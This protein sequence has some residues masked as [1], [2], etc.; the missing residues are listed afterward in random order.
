MLAQNLQDIIARIEKARIAY[1]RHQIVRIVAVSKTQ[2]ADAIRTLY[3]AGQRAFGENR[4]QD[5]CDKDAALEALPI[6][7]HFIGT[8]QTNKIN[9]LLALRPSLLHSLHSQQLAHALQKRLEKQGQN[10][11]AL[12]QINAAREDSKHGVAPESASETYH[13]I[14]ET[15]PNITLCGL[16]TIGAHTDEQ[17]KIQQSFE[18]TKKLFDTLPDASILSMGMSDDFELAIA[19]GSNMVRIGSLLFAKGRFL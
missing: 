7:W 18:I 19:C 9:A 5:L 11:R 15:C 12:L 4:V 8:L 13:A 16:M 17:R 1:S 6:E 10:L 14:R 3:E 2:N